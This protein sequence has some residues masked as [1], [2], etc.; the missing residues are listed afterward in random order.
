MEESKNKERD[1][2]PAL[3]R[4]FLSRLGEVKLPGLKANV[5]FWTMVVCGTAADLWSKSAVFKWL[6]QKPEGSYSIIDG[7]LQFVM[8]LNDGAAWGLA[9]GMRGFLMTISIVALVA[10]LAIFLNS[11]RERTL[12]HFGLGFFTAGVCGNLYDRA[13]NQGLVRDFV[14]VVYWPGRHWPAFNVGD[15]MLCIGVGLIILCLLTKKSAQKRDRQR[16]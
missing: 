4:A 15:S 9:S 1:A 10:S 2:R 5:I 12:F 16:K 3:G 6:E 13:F 11:R 14:D 8:A 7:F